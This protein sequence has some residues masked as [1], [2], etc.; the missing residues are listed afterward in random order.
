MLCCLLLC[1]V[2]FCKQVKIGDVVSVCMY[3]CMHACMYVC[4]CI[5]MYVCAYA[6][7][8]YT[9]TQLYMYT[10]TCCVCLHFSLS[11][12]GLPQSRAANFTLYS[13]VSCDLDGLGFRV[14]GV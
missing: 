9:G 5:C 6:C 13:Q 1:C 14:F 10:Y 8:F 3:L 12:L 11:F 2:M 7:M 4:V